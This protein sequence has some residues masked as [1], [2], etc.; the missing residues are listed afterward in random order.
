VKKRDIHPVLRSARPP[1]HDGWHDTDEGRQILAHILSTTPKEETHM[2]PPTRRRPARMALIA[3]GAVAAT[4]A[5]ALLAGPQL[6]DQDDTAAGKGKQS[7]LAFFEP[8]RFG[9]GMR[10]VEQYDSLD[11]AAEAASA[12]VM[13]EVV[14]VRMTRVIEG[15]GGDRL[16]MIGV[17]VRPV[18]ILDGAL[19]E[20]SQ[21]Q[22]TV[23]FTGG[24]EDPAAAVEQ[25]KSQLPE[26]ESV[27]F[28]RSKAEEGERLLEE[29]KQAG[30]T[31]SADWVRAVK[32]DRPYYRVV[33][34]QG[35]FVQDEQDVINPI[36]GE[37]GTS[38]TMVA[39]G[40]KYDEV[41]HLADHVREA[42]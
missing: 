8:L 30:R 11:A 24:G 38:D 6:F 31:P 1:A 4:T 16:Y 20:A 29:L 3:A 41:S 25:M 26:R 2:T 39:E 33:S 36:V 35:L 37:D 19:G 7:A 13:A 34:S 22:L 42:R 27:W 18:E 10:E 5:V 40:E 23:E 32:G 14:D 17:I 9:T 21:Q 15:E 28:L 12:V